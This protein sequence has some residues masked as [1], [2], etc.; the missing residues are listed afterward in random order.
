MKTL[1]FSRFSTFRRLLPPASTAPCGSPHPTRLQ[2]TS[3]TRHSRNRFLFPFCFFKDRSRRGGSPGRS[4]GSREGSWR[5]GQNGSPSRGQSNY[6]RVGC[7]PNPNPVLKDPS[8]PRFPSP[9]G[10]GPRTTPTRSRACRKAPTHS[11][12]SAPPDVFAS[13]C[14]RKTTPCPPAA[15][16]PHTAPCSPPRHPRF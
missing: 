12:V 14:C 5:G 11:A 10:T 13:R 4:C 6:C 16:S 8:P 1:R 3:E 7:G 9:S 15:R 2:I